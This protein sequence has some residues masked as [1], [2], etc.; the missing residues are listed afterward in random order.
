MLAI[1]TM[2][3]MVFVGL[4]PFFFPRV[5]RMDLPAQDSQRVEASLG[6]AR[7]KFRNGLKRSHQ[8]EVVVPPAGK[9]PDCFGI[10]M[11]HK[12]E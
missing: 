5:K 8:A 1:E 10:L 9:G 3:K 11:A 7:M 12:T 6:E 2:G 4:G